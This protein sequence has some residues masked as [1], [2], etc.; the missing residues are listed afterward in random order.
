MQSFNEP[1]ESTK[2]E[3]SN[4]ITSPSSSAASNTLDALLALRGVACLIVIVFHCGLQGDSLQKSIVVG[5]VDLSWLVSNYGVMGVWI[6]FCLSG[7]LMGKAFFNGRYKFNQQ[8]VLNFWRNRALRILPLYS[9]TVLFLSILVYP[10]IL[11]TENLGVLLRVCTFTYQIFITPESLDF[12]VSIWSLSTEV[13]FYL[14]VPFLYGILKQFTLNRRNIGLMLI[15]IIVGLFSFKLLIWLALKPIIVNTYY[16]FRYWYA[17]LATN[18]DIFLIGFL[19]NPLI[20]CIHEAAMEEK[21]ST[22]SN[23]VILKNQNL[24]FD[25]FYKIIAVILLILLYFFTAYHYY[26]LGLLE[27]NSVSLS[28]EIRSPITIF[29][30][31]PLTALTIAYFIF[32]FEYQMLTNHRQKLSFSALLQNPYR[33]LEVL[34]NLSYGLYLWHYPV[35]ENIAPMITSSVAIESFYLR[36]TSTF[37][38][39]LILATT[40]YYTVELPA[41]RWKVY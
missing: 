16:G 10:E 25:K 1:T 32:S 33:V 7:Y 41:A 18:L 13:Q 17:P 30:L 2:S 31:Q 6:F 21:N 26:H 28:P 40:T 19:M 12:N 27:P 8:G 29:I 37:V 4:S 23:G 14:L 38:L 36:L 3:G 20:G 5:E 39:S 15:V 9:F 35:L 22:L 24:S 34:G 11:K